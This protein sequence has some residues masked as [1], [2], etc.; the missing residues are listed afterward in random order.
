MPVTVLT[1]VPTYLLTY[2]RAC[3]GRERP[4]PPGLL[5]SSFLYLHTPLFNNV[6][7][8]LV[9]YQGEEMS[10]RG[11]QNLKARGRFTLDEL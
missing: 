10:L 1:H 5:A 7:Q 2:L 3:S 6:R 8:F 9:R 4:H 11:P